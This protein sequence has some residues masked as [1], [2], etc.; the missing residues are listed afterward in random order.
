MPLYP[1]IRDYITGTKDKGGVITL[2]LPP[3]EALALRY[4]VGSVSHCDVLDA[5]EHQHGTLAR[6]L[7]HSQDCCY[8]VFS[9]LADLLEDNARDQIVDL[10][11][12]LV[13]KLERTENDAS[14][15][16]EQKPE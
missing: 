13:H 2:S 4:F 15:E 10:A 5:V 9:V 3:G 1:S 16:P 8:N 14:Q 7:V 12:D 11:G 6:E